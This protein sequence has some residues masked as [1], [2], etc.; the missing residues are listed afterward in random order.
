MS[1]LLIYISPLDTADVSPHL[2]HADANSLAH[3]MSHGYLL[4]SLLFIELLDIRKGLSNIV[5]NN[6][7]GSRVT[8]GY[9]HYSFNHLP[10]HVV[11]VMFLLLVMCFLFMH[12]LLQTTVYMARS[13]KYSLKK[14]PSMNMPY[15]MA[16]NMP[17]PKN[18]FIYIFI[19]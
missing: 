6:Q 11:I 9:T 14:V 18:A 19:I 4:L 10:S 2:S 8:R 3:E 7:V 5:I 12:K 17:I 16:V 15:K 13:T 1:I